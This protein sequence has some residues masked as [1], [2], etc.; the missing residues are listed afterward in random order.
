[1]KFEEYKS[2][3]MSKDSFLKLPE[4][5]QELYFDYLNSHI[6]DNDN[7]LKTIARIDYTY[8]FAESPIEKIFNLA[9]D[10]VSCAETMD[11]YWLIPQE[12]IV[13]DDGKFRVDFLF[14][15]EEVSCP[16]REFQEDYFLVIEC[17][18]H[19]YHEKTKEQVAKRN[20]RDMALK[21]AGY[22][23]LHLS[24]SQIYREPMKCARQVVEYINSKVK[25]IRK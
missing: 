1:M 21:K 4:R 5:A 7:P 16:W 2:G 11:G 10:L 24:G 6:L 9:F 14:S 17:D 8:E 23:V 12:T 13:T 18:G 15:T 20:D 25:V 19:D 3:K 22:D